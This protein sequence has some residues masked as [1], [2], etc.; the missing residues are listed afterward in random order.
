MRDHLGVANPKGCSHQTSPQVGDESRPKPT[1][2]F[3]NGTACHVC[4]DLWQGF[5]VIMTAEVVLRYTRKGTTVCFPRP[6]M[7]YSQSMTQTR[8]NI[9]R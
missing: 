8:G 1:F 9:P 4:W 3:S 2:M 5:G 6:C 7:R